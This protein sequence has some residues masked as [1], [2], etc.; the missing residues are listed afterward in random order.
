MSSSIPGEPA[1]R[2]QP[3]GPDVASLREA[4]STGGVRWVCP[5][6]RKAP[7]DPQDPSREVRSHL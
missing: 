1:D 2:N 4:R 6:H 3:P 5:S 7:A